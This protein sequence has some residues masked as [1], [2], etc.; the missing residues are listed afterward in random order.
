MSSDIHQTPDIKPSIKPSTKLTVSKSHD[1][2]I[3]VNDVS[4]VYNVYANP[5]D[6]LKQIIWLGNRKFYKEFGALSNISFSVGRG[7]TIGVIG[8]NGSGKSTLLQLICQT[9]TP[10][11]GD[12]KIRGR[13]AALL[14]LGAGFNPEFTG[15]EN[16]Y[17]NATILGMSRAEIDARF[18]SIKDFADLGDFIEQPVKTYSSGMYVRLAFATAINTDPDILVVD[19][20]LSVGDEAF[21][22]K[23]FARIEQIQQRGGTI[24][25]VSHAASSILQ[26]CTRAILLDSGEKILEGSPKFVV[27][28]YQRLMNLSGEDAKSVRAEIKA[29][30][31]ANDVQADSDNVSVPNTEDEKIEEVVSLESYNP[32]LVPQST[33]NYET[34]GATI[35]EPRILNAKGEQVNILQMGK[36]YRYVYPVSFDVAAQKVGFGMLIKTLGGLE[37]AGGTTSRTQHLLTDTVFPGNHMEVSFPFICNF[38]PGT[39]FCNSGVSGEINGDRQFLHRILDAVMFQ[40]AI[41]AEIFATGVVD[42]LTGPPTVIKIDAVSNN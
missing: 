42:V 15:R 34:Q 8:R 12:V 24:L 41:E 28:Q 3:S 21:Q 35:G 13:L 1:V 6:R 27:N 29:L 11:S 2:A 4:K 7:E 19:E 33:V 36:A 9:L 16:V 22:R 18:D 30:G 23:C 37:I 25:F 31:I 10:S 20:A 26:L 5:S 17:L 32:S 39:Y 38:V 14:E 40:V